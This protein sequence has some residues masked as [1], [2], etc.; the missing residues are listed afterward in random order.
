MVFRVHPEIR[1]ADDAQYCIGGPEH[2]PHVVSQFRL[3]P[4][5]QMELDVNLDIGDYIIR[6]TRLPGQQS[7]RVR[8][9]HA[10]SRIQTTVSR[11]G[12]ESD[13]PVVRAGQVS[14]FDTT[15]VVQELANPLDKI[16]VKGKV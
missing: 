15:I 5:E 7:I 13:V 4:N 8:G 11:L 1:E 3:A 16:P 2:S 9:I 14:F 12:T 10:T 6:S